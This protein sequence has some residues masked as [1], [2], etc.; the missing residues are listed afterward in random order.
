VTR[1]RW[2]S[3]SAH[4]V[5]TRTNCVAGEDA[6]RRN[7]GSTGHAVK[8]HGATS[9]QLRPGECGDDRPSDSPVTRGFHCIKRRLE[10]GVGSKPAHCPI[11]GEN[12]GTQS[13]GGNGGHGGFPG[14]LEACNQDEKF[15]ESDIRHGALSLP[16]SVPARGNV[17]VRTSSVASASPESEAHRCR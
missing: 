2:R 8:H 15:P 10:L 5:M 11:V 7:F 17:T 4:S 16:T 14:S 12:R 13:L 9:P 6:T 1:V 3:A